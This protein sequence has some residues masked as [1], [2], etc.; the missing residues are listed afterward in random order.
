MAR[1]DW[2]LVTSRAELRSIAPKWNDL[3][4]RSHVTLPAAQAEPLAIWLEEFAPDALFRAVVLR[5]GDRLLASLPLVERR[6]AGAVTVGSLP[7]NYLSLCGDLA[8]DQDCDQQA[9]VELLADAFGS[10]PWRLVTLQDVAIDAPRWQLLQQALQKTGQFAEFEHRWDTG[11]TDIPHDWD[12]FFGSR[13]RKLRSA[14]KRSHER[15]RDSGGSAL[16]VIDDFAPHEVEPYLRRGFEV[17]DRSWKSGAGTSVLRVPGL[18]RFFGRQA[19]ALAATG[20]LA[21]AYLE[22]AS[23]PIGFLYGIHAKGVFYPA[24]IGYDERFAAYS[25]GQLL[26]CQVLERL[27]RQPHWEYLDFHGPLTSTFGRWATRSYRSGDLLVAANSKLGSLPWRARLKL[28]PA[29][30]DL[31]NRWRRQP[32][33]TVEIYPLHGKRHTDSTASW[34]ADEIT[35]L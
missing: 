25:P 35:Q 29:L 17:E 13:S 10:L 30:R 18:F 22:H 26:N 27:N 6:L 15:L 8:I 5:Q 3:W 9:V 11:V 32:P 4:R 31:R 2:H 7:N 20:N 19:A 14:M 33:S 21:L 12:L 1:L 34:A 16:V 23:Q 24:K 28:R